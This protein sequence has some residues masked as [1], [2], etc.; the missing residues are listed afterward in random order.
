MPSA[1]EAS[2]G[3]A[4][5]RAV[6]RTSAEDARGSDPLLTIHPW[7]FYIQKNMENPWFPFKNYL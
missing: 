6:E 2:G 4:T 7:G 5:R 1:P 3:Q